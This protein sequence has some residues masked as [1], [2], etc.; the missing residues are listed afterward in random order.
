MKKN[1]SGKADLER[2]GKPRTGC[3]ID[4]WIGCCFIGCC[5]VDM[6][7]TWKERMNKAWFFCNPPTL[8]YFIFV[9][10]KFQLKLVL[11]TSRMKNVSAT[12]ANDIKLLL[13]EYK[14]R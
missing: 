14:K 5:C 1:P 7:V 6:T 13:G 10:G 3:C 12:K 4:C 11:A 2:I 9:L 8:L